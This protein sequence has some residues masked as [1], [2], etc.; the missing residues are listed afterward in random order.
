MRLGHSSK[1]QIKYN[2]S[3]CVSK[4]LQADQEGLLNTNAKREN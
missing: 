4:L 3:Q 2:F 1:A